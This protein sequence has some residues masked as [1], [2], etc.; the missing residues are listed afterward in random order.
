VLLGP[1]AMKI[2]N[3]TFRMDADVLVAATNRTPEQESIAR[4]ATI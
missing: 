4:W 3:M 1:M 2:L